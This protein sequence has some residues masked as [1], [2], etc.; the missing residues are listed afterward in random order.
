[1]ALL[2]GYNHA[3]TRTAE[4][5]IAAVV[6]L[7]LG[8]CDLHDG[9]TYSCLREGDKDKHCYGIVEFNVIDLGNGPNFRAFITNVYARA[10]L[11]GDGEI[12]DEFWVVQNPATNCGGNPSI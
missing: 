4:L 6:T 3:L 10:L 7:L 5:L 1:M 11:S 9:R 8:S 2:V 12:N